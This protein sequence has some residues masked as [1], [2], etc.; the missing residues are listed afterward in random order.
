MTLESLRRNVGIVLQDVFVFSGTFRDNITYGM[1]EVSEKRMIE[2]ARVAQLHDFITSLQDGYNTVVGERGIK[3]SGGQR[4]RLAIART[5]LRDP[6]ILIL[7]D[8]TSSVDTKTELELQQAL[9]DVMRDRTTFVIA[10]RLS[11]VRAATTIMVIE[12][13]EIVQ[14]GAHEELIVQGGYYRQIYESQLLPTIEEALK[15]V[16]E[17]YRR[18]DR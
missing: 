10:H 4:Q 6:P 1:E 7:D 13:G 11:T 14:Q 12:D 8:S 9:A 2:A 17:E 16:S 5:I 15:Q 3:L 18:S